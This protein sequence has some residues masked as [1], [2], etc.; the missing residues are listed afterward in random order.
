MYTD[1]VT[2][3]MEDQLLAAQVAIGNALEDE[4]I[5]ERLSRLGFGEE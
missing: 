2:L 4:E 1:Y 3:T 5:K